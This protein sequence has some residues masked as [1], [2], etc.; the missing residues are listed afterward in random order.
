MRSAPHRSKIPSEAEK[1][2]I[3]TSK[4][5]ETHTCKNLPSFAGGIVGGGGGVEGVVGG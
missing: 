1:Y 2:C 3:N 5:L 4:L